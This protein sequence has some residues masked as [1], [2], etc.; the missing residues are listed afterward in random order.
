M[1]GNLRHMNLLINL[2]ITDSLVI[3]F[4]NIGLVYKL[5]PF[6]GKNFFL[7]S[8]FN[9]LLF[10][11]QCFRQHNKKIGLLIRFFLDQTKETL[12]RLTKSLLLLLFLE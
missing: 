3:A 1:A 10:K 2:I 7:P 12:I 9:L 6:E 8:L 5:F 4:D 11:G